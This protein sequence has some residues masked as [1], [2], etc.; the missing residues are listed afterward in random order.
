MLKVDIIEIS[1]YNMGQFLGEYEGQ[2]YC[3][4]VECME[5]WDKLYDHLTK[6]VYVEASQVGPGHLLVTKIY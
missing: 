1:Y 2:T 5:D 3:F 4:M 6:P